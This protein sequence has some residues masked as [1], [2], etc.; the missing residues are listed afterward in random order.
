LILK[1]VSWRVETAPPVL[2]KIHKPGKIKADP[3]YGRF[4]DKV[5]GKSAIVE[6]EADTDLRDTEQVPLLE[7][8]GIEAFIRRE[9]LPYTADAW[10][11]E[12]S[13]KIGYE[14]SFTRH[15]YKPQ[16]LR[17]LEEISADILEVEHEA[18]GLLD[19]LLKGAR[20]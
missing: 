17:T 11:K 14:I 10:I 18:V 2:A 16:P 8:G 13:A 1:A 12:N 20:S 15:F 5:N 19:N 3:L 4:E 7:E 6:F 9:V